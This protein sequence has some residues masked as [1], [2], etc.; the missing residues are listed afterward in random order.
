MLRPCQPFLTEIDWS[1]FS[2]FLNPFFWYMYTLYTIFE[3]D[4]NSRLSPILSS[5]PSGL[6]PGRGWVHSGLTPSRGWVQSGLSPIRG[7]VPF[8]VQSIRGWVPFGVGS[9]RGSV[10]S[11]LSPFEVESF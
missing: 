4:R 5:V 3:V 11:R 7:S 1:V 9:I 10:H 6:S 8:V 2:L